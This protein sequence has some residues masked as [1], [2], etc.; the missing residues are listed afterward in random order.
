ML[1]VITKT[2]DPKFNLAAEEYLLKNFEEEIFFLWRNAPSI[3]IGKNQNAYSE[4]DIDYVKEKNITVVRRQ[5]GG[6][7]VFHDLGN[8]NFS[9]ITSYSE[10]EDIS[11]ERFTRPV[12]GFINTLGAKAEFAGRNDIVIDGQ[13]ISGNAQT[14]WKNRFLHHGTL[15]FCANMNDLSK[16]L[17]V[18]PLKIQ[19]KGIKSV[20]ARVTNIASHINE[21]ISVEQFMERLFEYTAKNDT[22]GHIYELTAKDIAAIEKLKEEKYAA[23]SWNFGENPSYSFKK[24]AKYTAGIIEIGMNIE[25]EHIKDI[26]IKG[27]FFASGEIDGLEKI[28]CGLPHKEED[29]RNVLKGIDLTP[30]IGG[31]TEDELVAVLF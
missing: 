28:L 1:L 4:I 19:S 17:T 2:T 16:A 9:Y 18:N 26:S 24:S 31:I 25:N 3:I 21:N 7:A 30:Y 14:I 15:L 5:T 20:K 12:C 10:G 23:W 22:D 6:G 11:F 8:V 27:D 13:K 29:I